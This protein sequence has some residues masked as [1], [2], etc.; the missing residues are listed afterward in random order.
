MKFVAA[1]FSFFFRT[2]M[3]EKLLNLHNFS[4]KKVVEKSNN[5]NLK[6]IKTTLPNKSGNSGSLKK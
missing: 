5:E 4:C 6:L 1:P 3:R 2:F